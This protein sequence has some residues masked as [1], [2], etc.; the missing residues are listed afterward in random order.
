M[1]LETY[2]DLKSEI[3]G[4][5]ARSDVTASSSV[6]DTFIDF[7]ES[8]FNKKLRVLRMRDTT[9]LTTVGATATVDLPSDFLEAYSLEFS[10]SPRD[11]DYLPKSVFKKI[12][13]D[14]IS[15]RP[16]ACTLAW[17]GTLPQL[18]FCPT[19]DGAYSL[20]L[21]YYQKITALSDSNTT[22]WLLT[23]EPEAY[24]NASLYFA[25][26]RYRSPLAADYKALMQEDIDRINAEDQAK[27]TIGGGMTMRVMGTIV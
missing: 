18:E 10:S 22:N 4:N 11:I 2:S 7:A 5:I 13:G 14:T 8:R 1:A 26:K 12:V 24:L 23:D 19:P 15:S 6:V 17:S 21:D 9:T 25:F 20:Y 3:A 27:Q 16:K